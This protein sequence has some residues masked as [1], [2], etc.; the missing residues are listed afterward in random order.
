M[1]KHPCG[2]DLLADRMPGHLRIVAPS[3]VAVAPIARPE[4][5]LHAPKQNDELRVFWELLI[6]RDEDENRS[7]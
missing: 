1:G 5:L 7:K 6:P 4:D 3:A 2:I